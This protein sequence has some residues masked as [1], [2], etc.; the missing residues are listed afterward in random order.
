M[1]ELLLTDNSIIIVPSNL[2]KKWLNTFEKESLVPRKIF[3]KEE[4]MTKYYF[5]YDKDAIYSLMKEY[6][7]QYNVA[8]MY[9]A[10]I[11][12]VSSDDFGSEKVRKIMAIKEYLKKENKLTYTPFFRE[13]LKGKR[14]I[15]LDCRLHKKDF[16]MISELENICNIEYFDEEKK[17]YSHDCIYSFDDIED[18]VAFVADKICSLVEKGISVSKIKL[19]GANSN[20]IPIIKRVF[21]W[22]N[23]PITFDDNSLFA[24]SIGQDFLK[25]LNTDRE[26]LLKYIENNYNLSLKEIQDIYNTFVNILNSYIWVD[27]LQEV[28]DFIEAD[29]KNITTPTVHYKEEIT[30]INSLDGALEDEYVF[31]LGFNQGDIPNTI[32]D[33]DYWSDTLKEK[34]GLETTSELNR[35]NYEKWLL[36]IKRTKNLIITTKTNSP[37]GTHYLSS[38]N[39]DLNLEVKREKISYN[40]SNIYNKIKLTEKL[41]TLIKY[42]E[43]EEDLSLLYS[44]YKEIPYA[45]YQS[46][47]QKINKDNLVKYLKNKFTLSYSTMNTYYQCGFRYYVANILKL[48][49]YEDRFSTL[50]GKLFHYILSICFDKDID[51]D[52]EYENYLSKC[53]YEFNSREKFFLKNL[54]DEL[55][56]IINTIKKQLENTSLNRQ[57]FEKKI[58]I[59]KNKDDMNIIFKGYVDKILSDE[60]K[61]VI[62]IVDYKTGNPDL[63]LN[64]I[65]YGLDLQLPVY[66]YLAKLQFPNAKIAGFYLQKILNNE[67][68]KDYKHTYLE[69]KEA[70]LKLQGYSNND[71]A[72]LEKLDSTY[73]ESTMIKGMRLTS[74]GFGTKKVLDD[75]KIEK[76]ISITNTKI[77]EAISNISDANFDINPKRIGTT[78][79]G[80]EYCNFRD[81]CFST[82]KNIIDLKEYKNMEFLGGDD[83]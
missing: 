80:C 8:L 83:E 18:E 68:S 76:L 32:K 69:L 52:L 60:E 6:N 34:L 20:Y 26:T 46:N 29:L 40:H 17:I 57:Y 42:N 81:I 41:D 53:D 30:I 25:N 4:F 16:L 23:L 82:E 54:K 65:I 49:K 79:K 61:S 15:F 35:E 12:D 2:K 22:F 37:L 75:E 45:S 39:E 43:Q 36:D 3:T 50:L 51:I 71:E 31:L 9:L 24:T 13:Y 48:D 62:A 38:L 1:K 78:N 63:N 28:K 66:L 70:N 72:I 33:E 11:Y 7:Y 56:F 44:N 58:V 5:S 21:D 19:C 10:H 64:N 47:Y 77:D 27:D 14:L 67:I 59:P 55:K 74:T 73:Q